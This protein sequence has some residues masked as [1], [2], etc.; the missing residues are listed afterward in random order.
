MIVDSIG[1]QTTEYNMLYCS[2]SWFMYKTAEGVAVP[3][4]S[5]NDSLLLFNYPCLGQSPFSSLA[6]KIS[7]ISISSLC[8]RASISSAVHTLL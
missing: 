5:G 4:P 7:N 6:F 3:L 8:L 1:F 2:S